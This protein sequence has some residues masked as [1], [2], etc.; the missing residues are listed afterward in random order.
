MKILYY[1][2]EFDNTLN[3]KRNLIINKIVEILN[4]KKGW[5]KLGYK[6]H[7]LETEEK[8]SNNFIIKIV[9]QHFI[10]KECSMKGLSCA[11]TSKNII[12]INFN[13]WK[14]GS[15]KS[16]LNVQDYRVYLIN[17]EVG[18]ILGR[19]HNKCG[20]PNTKVPVMVQQTLGI[21]KCKPNPWPLYWE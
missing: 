17:H 6:F 8:K 18:H 15:S 7:Y 3:L 9:P 10:E 2:I 19:S 13:R 20:N 16:K 1:K 5:Y 12:Y 11:D 21:Q 14:N 4:N